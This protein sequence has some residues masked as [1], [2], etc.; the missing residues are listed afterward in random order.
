MVGKPPSQSPWMG[1]ATS[2]QGVLR[3][4]HHYDPQEGWAPL[5]L[6]RIWPDAGRENKSTLK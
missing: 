6:C 1:R 2:I 4:L 3:P 5:L